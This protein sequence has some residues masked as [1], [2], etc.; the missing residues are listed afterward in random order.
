MKPAYLLSAAA[1]M[2][3]LAPA[4]EARGFRSHAVF[5]NGRHSVTRDSSFTHTRG[6]R[7]RDTTWTGENG[8][9]RTT[10]VTRTHDGND[11]SYNRDTTFADG[12]SRSIDRERDGNGDGTGEITRTITDRQGDTRTQT[13]SYEVSRQ[14]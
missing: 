3:A 11:A 7:E 8:R 10:D 12:T 5:S 14:P 9:T 13:G 4:A 6:A 2:L 1:L